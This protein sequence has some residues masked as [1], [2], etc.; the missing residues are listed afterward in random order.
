[1]SGPALHATVEMHLCR[2]HGPEG[3]IHIRMGWPHSLP[4][5]QFSAAQRLA[6]SCWESLAQTWE[7]GVGYEWPSPPCD[8]G[9]AFM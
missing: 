6:D 9:D 1:M 4:G 7:G 5:H 3:S 8:R 2:A